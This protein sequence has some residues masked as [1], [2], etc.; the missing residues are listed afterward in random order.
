[1]WIFLGDGYLFFSRI[2]LRLVRQRIH[3][4]SV[5]ASVSLPEEYEEIGIFLE[6]DFWIFPVFSAIWFDNGY[7]FASVY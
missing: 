5:F 3:I 1:M 7:M 6:D 4:V 2:Q